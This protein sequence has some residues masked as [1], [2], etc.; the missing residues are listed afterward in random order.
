[1]PAA[2]GIAATEEEEDVNSFCS[3]L[4]EREVFAF[5]G[6]AMPERTGARPIATAKAEPSLTTSPTEHR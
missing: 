2:R 3:L 4:A 6:R 5:L 1:M